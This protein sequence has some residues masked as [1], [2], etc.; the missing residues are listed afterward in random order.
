MPPVP[1]ILY[2]VPTGLLAEQCDRF[3][4][5]ARAIAPTV[6]QTYPPHC[7]L[8]GFFHRPAHRVQESC[9]ALAVALDRAGL[10]PDG[11][12]ESCE[13]TVRGLHHRDG[14]LGLELDSTRLRG[15]AA[16]FAAAAA[17]LRRPGDDALRLKEWLHLSLA[18]DTDPATLARHAALARAVVEPDLQCDWE[19]GLWR[20]HPGD[21]W[22]RLAPSAFSTP[23]RS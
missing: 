22:E 12:A 2:A 11:R 23:R 17:P 9:D 14:W 4:R 6:A 13:V 18:Y 1:L 21:Q 10:G 8:T 20:R 3:F 5:M 16:A 7:T 15:T 19:V